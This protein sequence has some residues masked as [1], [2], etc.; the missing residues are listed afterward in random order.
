M[1]FNEVKPERKRRE[2]EMS[3]P[4]PR[5]RKRLRKAKVSSKSTPSIAQTNNQ[6][7]GF[8]SI[9]EEAFANARNKD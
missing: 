4:R 9:M 5:V 8:A 2:K 6:P 7:S 1:S 3:R